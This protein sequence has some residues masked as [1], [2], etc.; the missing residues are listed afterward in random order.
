M[1]NL[2]IGR[3]SDF[4]KMR[5]EIRSI[6]VE[7]SKKAGYNLPV[8]FDLSVPPRSE[9]GDLATNIAL[10]IAKNNNKEPREV[11]EKIISNISSGVIKKIE[12]AGA[13]FINIFIKTEYLYEKLRQI[14][15][16]G[17]KYGSNLVGAGAIVNVEYIS[18][19]PTGPVHIG[20]ARGGP[21]GEAI[22]NLLEFCGY[23][24]I[25]SFYVNDIGGQIDKLAATFYYWYEILNGQKPIFPEGGYPGE[26]VKEITEKVK[27]TYKSDLSELKDEE[28][29]IAFFKDK[30][31][32]AM[33]D[34]IRKEV[35]L[36]DITIDDWIFQSELESSGKTEAIINYLESRGATDKREG[37]LWFKNESDPDFA[38]KESVL[39]KSDGRET[40]T[41]FADDIA[42]HKYKVDQGA[43][44]MIDVWGANHH[45]HV[46]R[47]HAAMQA[48]GI[49]AKNLRVVLYQN[50]RIKNGEEIIKMSKREGN[51]V[52][53]S[54]VIKHGV[55]A[56]VFKYF[57][58]NQ[59]NNTPMDFDVKLAMEKSEKNPVYYV[60]YAHARIC[61]I[62]KKAKVA[63]PDM[64][65][66]E[67][68]RLKHP[69]ELAL[70][71][72]LLLF[73]DLVS[74]ALKDYQMQVFPH[75][76]HRVASLFHEFYNDCRV[77]G[78]EKELEK[79]RLALVE[80]TKIVLKN[81]LS[82]CD[83]GSP[84]KM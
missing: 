56:D 1:E 46:A 12:I 74:G 65:N 4:N 50:V 53:L 41:Y 58:L 67:I 52:L 83:I 32:R 33:V 72:E 62:L 73:P 51:F 48:I 79:A 78:E 15:K 60:Q 29:F 26:Y 30:G 71:K 2:N 22:A 49:D 77:I 7:A 25:R 80:A 23:K 45:G 68:N 63:K 54:D 47:M 34:R 8:G 59:N 19:N 27:S 16:L 17:E 36:L 55:G 81:S 76:A 31:V 44:I 11:A 57:V 13:G 18:A 28:S 9:M 24:V 84:E 37:A 42:C 6:I 64:A 5:E 61:S 70:I 69:R 14:V 82:I 40:L 38:D 43:D 35:L 75:Y 10:I 20:N 21:I 3:L 66:V 39:R